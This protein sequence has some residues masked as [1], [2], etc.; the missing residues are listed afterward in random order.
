[1][2]FVS[3][4]VDEDRDEDRDKEESMSIVKT[5]R[6]KLGFTLIEMLVVI[7]IIGI[8]AGIVFKM[9]SMVSRRGEVAQALQEM[10]AIAGALTEFYAEY[11]QYPPVKG[12]GYEFENVGMQHPFFRGRFLPQNP[13]WTGNTLFDY[14]GLIPWL[15]PRDPSDS[16]RGSDW[17]LMP[18]SAIEHKPNVQWIGDTA[19]DF[20]AKRRWARFLVDIELLKSENPV[21]P[22]RVNSGGET[23]N[24]PYTNDTLTVNDP[25]GSE[26]QYESLPPHLDFKLWSYGPDR[27]ADTEDDIFREGWD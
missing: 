16:R 8:L 19:R 5:M 20:A 4:F 12:M 18:G 15:W 9:F 2:I 23:V 6:S 22:N 24:W 1:M 17:P 26:Y 27:T 11:G 25:W 7:V 10:Q 13:D 14:S 3:I 21:V